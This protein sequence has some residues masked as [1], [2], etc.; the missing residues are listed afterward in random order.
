ME[1]HARRAPSP[2]HGPGLQSIH[3]ARPAVSIPSW[4]TAEALETWPSPRF[5]QG[6][7]AIVQHV[8]RIAPCVAGSSISDQLK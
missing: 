1:R 2:L 3:S 6:V 7:L 8:S 4:P 5:E